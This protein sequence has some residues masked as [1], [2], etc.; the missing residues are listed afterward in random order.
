M[1]KNEWKIAEK[2]PENFGSPAYKAI[3]ERWMSKYG[4]ILPSEYWTETASLAFD[5]DWLKS[6]KWKKPTSVPTPIDY[7]I[8]GVK[9]CRETFAQPPMLEAKRKF[10][11]TYD[12]ALGSYSWKRVLTTAF[13][14]IW[15]GERLDVF[16]NMEYTPCD[17]Q[18]RMRKF[19][20]D[21]GFT[22]CG[23]CDPRYKAD[24]KW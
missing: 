5:D 2:G 9:L 20:I 24:D 16:E 19:L 17:Q 6:G 8:D 3:K 23:C 4:N 12:E 21:A 22:D 1:S 10:L 15:V 11:S 18:L 14:E 7:E 13:D